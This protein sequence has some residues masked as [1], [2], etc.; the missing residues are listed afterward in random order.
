MRVGDALFHKWSCEERGHNEM[1]CI[2]V[3]NCTVSSPTSSA[4]PIIDEFGCSL[5]PSVLP[6]VEHSSDMVAGLAANAFSL[7]IDQASSLR[8]SIT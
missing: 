1:Y 2:L 5:F 8:L 6:H 3:H 7:D 4:V